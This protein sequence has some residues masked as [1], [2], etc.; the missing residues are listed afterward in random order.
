MSEE[1]Y[2]LIKKAKQ[3]AQSESVNETDIQK[4]I[5]SKFIRYIFTTYVRV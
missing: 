5:L 2:Q 3:P 4:M 1:L